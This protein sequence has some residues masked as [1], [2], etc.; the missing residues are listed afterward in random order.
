MQNFC[1][2]HKSFITKTL[3]DGGPRT[4]DCCLQK[5]FTSNVKINCR[6]R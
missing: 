1:K 4:A 6:H 5:Y 3:N 2:S